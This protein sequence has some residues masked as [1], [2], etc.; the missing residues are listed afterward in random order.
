[1]MRTR[2]VFLAAA[3][4]LASAGPAT[5]Q[6]T[7][8]PVKPQGIVDF[9]F[10]ASSVD[11]DRARFERYRD[12]RDAAA[13][14]NFGL[15]REG[16]NWFMD[17][18]AANVGY[19]DQ[20]FGALFGTGRLK[21]S[22]SWNQVPLFYSSTTRTPY[23]QAS[24]GV[25]T[26][27][28]ATRLAVQNKQ[29][30]GIPTTVAQ[31]ANASVYRPL[32]LLLD[33][34][35]RRDTASMSLAYTATREVDVTF[36]LTSYRRAGNMPWGASFSFNG[37]VEV[38]LPIDNRTTDFRAGIEWANRKGML[39]LAYDGSYFDNGIQTLVWDSPFRATDI[40][41]SAGY[42]NGDGTS[43]GRMA[44]SPSNHANTLS[45]AGM[46][47]LPARSS[48]TGSFSVSSLR[49]NEP[50]IPLT[51][52]SAIPVTP[53]SRLS[54]E[55][56][57]RVV[58][59][60]IGFSSR[61][62]RYF[63]FSARYRY[64]NHDNRTPLFDGDRYVRFDQYMT[65]GQGETEPFSI[66]RQNFRMDASF[67]P[68]RYT[69]FRVGYGREAVERTYRLFDQT[70]DNTLRASID[71]VGNAYVTVRGLYEHSSREGSGFHA[72]A[73]SHAGQQ[74][75]MRHFDVANR[76]RD[77]TTLH[78]DVT[79]ISVLGFSAS[80]A[81]GRDKYPA[82]QFGLLDNDHDSYTVGVHVF[83]TDQV[84]FG[85][86]YGHEKYN[87]MQMS[88]N[89]NP[90]G[91]DYGSWTDA[92]RDWQL[93]ASEK[94]NTLGFNLDLIRALPK[95]E[96]RLG[97]DLSDSDQGFLHSGPR[98]VALAANNTFEPLPNVTNKW[99]RATADVRY[100]VSRQ[101][102][103]G[104]TYWR[105]KYDVNDFAT[106]DLPDGSPRVDYLGGLILGYG[107]RPYSANTGFV[108][109]FYLF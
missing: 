73:L 56:D 60:N 58:N 1:M 28:A 41:N 4:L 80:I 63:G 78:L 70:V 46:M 57:V 54:A 6:Q 11:G 5:A 33:T 45:A 23:L 27:D 34:R 99:Q 87:A 86:T 24:S 19:T 75:E 9:G 25:F 40:A 29:A 61:P 89:A 7:S 18:A 106:I 48:L 107:Y 65:T 47:R 98:I 42:S 68:I 101:I 30:I 12:V 71:L 77:R 94:V 16:P 8:I 32:A 59:T 21:G 90:A 36:S 102:G 66:E 97:Y 35:S 31:A 37:G 17:L 84:S 50:L 2:F 67:T 91:T 108:R 13:T 76:D 55:G 51:I 49:Q 43:I 20:Q 72:H 100:F 62:N 69:A 53:L 81:S 10:R 109:V 14:L 95:T 103:I 82:Q 93:D 3:L 83:P 38:P 88:R 15:N 39:R 105:D 92:S 74:P 44:L 79:P 52:N 96:I 85:L 64:H 104:A 22:F 26:L